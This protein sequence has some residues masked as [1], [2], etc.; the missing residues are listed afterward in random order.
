VPQ[1]IKTSPT[2][3]GR[4]LIASWI[5]P[6]DDPP[7]NWSAKRTLLMFLKVFFCFQV[8]GVFVIPAWFCICAGRETEQ[9]SNSV[10]GVKSFFIDV[11]SEANS[12][13]RRRRDSGLSILIYH[14]VEQ[15]KRAG[16]TLLFSA[17]ARAL[18]VCASIFANVR[19]QPLLLKFVHAFLLCNSNCERLR[20]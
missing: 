19:L 6:V 11:D 13:D 20:Q 5:P 18:A 9:R 12:Q 16:L 10:S 4:S 15:T 2:P 8:L 17:S 3:L 7:T 1:G 14:I